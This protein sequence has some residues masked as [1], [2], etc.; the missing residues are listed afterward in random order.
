MHDYSEQTCFADALLPLWW[1]KSALSFLYRVLVHQTSQIPIRL[2]HTYILYLSCILIRS[3]PL[4]LPGRGLC[5]LPED[6][7]CLALLRSSLQFLSFHLPKHSHTCVDICYCHLY[8]GIDQFCFYFP[9]DV[10][11]HLT[12]N[13]YC[14][15]S[16]ELVGPEPR[17]F[18]SNY[19]TRP[20]VMVLALVTLKK[21]TLT[22]RLP[23]WWLKQGQVDWM[24]FGLK[25]TSWNEDLIL[26]KGK[27]IL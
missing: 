22:S 9:D 10:V 21:V 13:N 20:C 18:D 3:T 15:V 26:L 19:H 7:G 4:Q 11:K 2:A 6:W 16:N 25:L 8:L 27:R 14:P 1:S 24:S 5:H 12:V 17:H 23:V